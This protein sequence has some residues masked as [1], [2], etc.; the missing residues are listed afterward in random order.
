[1]DEGVRAL[2][3]YY[4]LKMKTINEDGLVEFGFSTVIPTSHTET[5]RVINLA[6]IRKWFRDHD[7]E[8]PKEFDDAD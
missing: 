4:L 3:E 2:Y 6:S 1:M 7:L 8:V 5:V